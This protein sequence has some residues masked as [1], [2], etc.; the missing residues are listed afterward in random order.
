M[1]PMIVG[2]AQRIRNSANSGEVKV[3]QKSESVQHDKRRHNNCNEEAQFPQYILM[4]L[5]CRKI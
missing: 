3:L 5:G 4:E 2:T 1:G